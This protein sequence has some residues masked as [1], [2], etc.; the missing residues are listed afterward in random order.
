MSFKNSDA[1]FQFFPIPRFLEIRAMG[2]DISDN[3]IRVMDLA[4]TAKGFIPRKY[5]ERKIKSSSITTNREEI[6]KA[7]ISLKD[8]LDISFVRV[9]LPEEKAYLFKTEIPLVSPNEMTE[10]VSY[11]IE[12]NAPVSLSEIVF[13]YR[14]IGGQE[15]HG[16]IDVT[17]SVLPKMLVDDY[18]ILFEEAGIS[19]I[20]FEIEAQSISR[21]VISN[22]D[23]KPAMVIHVGDSKTG[24]TI[25]SGGVVQFTT[26]VPVGSHALTTIIEQEFK[27]TTDEARKIKYEKDFIHESDNLNVHRVFV[28]TCALLKDEI[29]K[30]YMYW[31]THKSKDF[32]GS[33][34]IDVIYISGKATGIPGFLD[35]M[36]S[37]LNAEVKSANVWQ[38]CFNEGEYIPSLVREEAFSYA[39]AIGLILPK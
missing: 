10:A 15:N 5:G 4:K 28:E 6:K 11:T 14:V 25:V 34:K 19:V 37:N 9:T 21:A 1:Y 17:V 35:Y 33:Q 36:S 29:N 20:S 7:I 26:T 23:M 39:P 22:E 3:A 13:D 30:H 18:V 27:V 31:L 8:E 38:N 12:E 24:I 2:M 16:H 32:N